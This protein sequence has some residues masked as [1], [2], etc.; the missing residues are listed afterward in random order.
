[1]ERHERDRRNQANFSR[2]RGL[3]WRCPLAPDTALAPHQRHKEAT[4]EGIQ[5]TLRRVECQSIV[6]DLFVFF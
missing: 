6:D 3:D 5:L 4:D 2:L 1:M